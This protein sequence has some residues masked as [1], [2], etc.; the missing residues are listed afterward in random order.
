MVDHIQLTVWYS[1]GNEIFSE[2]KS[3]GSLK[4][5][6]DNLNEVIIITGANKDKLKN[7]ELFDLQGKSILKYDF[8]NVHSENFQIPFNQS[9]GIYLWKIYSDASGRILIK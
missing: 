9:A 7:I 6:Y 3:A 1:I 2:M 5:N 8:N 4:V